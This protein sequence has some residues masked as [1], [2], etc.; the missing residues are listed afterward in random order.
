MSIVPANPGFDL[1]LY[2]VNRGGF[3]AVPIIAWFISGADVSAVPITPNGESSC[4][5]SQ[6]VRYPN[7]RV[8]DLSDGGQFEDAVTW[9]DF[10]RAAAP[11]DHKK[12]R[13]GVGFAI[14]A[15]GS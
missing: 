6:A 7:G 13:G 1:L 14:P 9:L 3:T 10:M 15:A 5:N 8:E 11:E 4:L 12:L 2:E